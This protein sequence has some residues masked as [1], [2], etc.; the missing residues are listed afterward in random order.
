MLHGQLLLALSAALP[1]L[2]NVY[3]ANTTLCSAQCCLSFEADIW[4][5]GL[6]VM[7]VALGKFPF[8]KEAEDGY[9]ALLQAL[10]GEDPV[11]ALNDLVEEELVFSDE[12]QSFLDQCLKKDPEERPSAKELLKHPFVSSVDVN[13]E[14]GDGAVLEGD[15]SDTAR[16]EIV[17]ISDTVVSYYRRLWAKQSEGSIA[18]TV[19][20]FNK[21]KLKRL[22]N[23][24]GLNVSVVQRK[25]RGVLKVLKTEILAHGLDSE[26][27]ETSEAN[28]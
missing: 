8:Q 28:P 12:F 23:Q 7:T 11:P 21:P 10:R 1:H 20:N 6:T 16:A 3:V 14:D 4:S 27:K 2:R 22:G 18:L 15:G 5:L 17:E 9:W 24:I 26:R 13:E 19:P 25:M